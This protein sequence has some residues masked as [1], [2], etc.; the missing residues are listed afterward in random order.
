MRIFWNKNVKITAA[1]GA[2]PPNLRLPSATEGSA[3]RPSR[4]YS[5]LLLQICPVHF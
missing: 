4:Y 2:P 1:S 5:C 3:P